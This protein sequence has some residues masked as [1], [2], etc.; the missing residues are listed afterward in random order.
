MVA[1]AAYYLPLAHVGSHG[2]DAVE[3]QAAR[4]GQSATLIDICGRDRE[5]EGGGGGEEEEEG[6]GG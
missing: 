1:A 4:P 2:V 5:E 3:S 6:E